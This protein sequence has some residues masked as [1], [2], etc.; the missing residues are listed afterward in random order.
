MVF[1]FVKNMI[2]LDLILCLLL[3]RA[4]KQNTSRLG[5]I[6]KQCNNVVLVFNLKFLFLFLTLRLIV[7]ITTK[8]FHTLGN[9]FSCYKDILPGVR[10]Q[11][12]HQ[13]D[14]R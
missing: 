11:F 6:L 5:T 14:L 10:F 8:G 12:C 3:R 9:I 2:F 7:S 13:T 4:L 1:F